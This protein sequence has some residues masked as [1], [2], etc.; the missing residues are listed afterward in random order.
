MHLV[1]KSQLKRSK[2]ISNIQEQ[3]FHKHAFFS[4]KAAHYQ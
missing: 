1:L 2:C 4:D 3:N